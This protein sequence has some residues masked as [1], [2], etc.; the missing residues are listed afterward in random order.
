[1]PIRP[2]ALDDRSFNDLV[3]EL[4]ARIPAHTPEWTTR[5]GDPGRTSWSCS[6]GWATPSSTAPT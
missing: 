6:P 1:M 5:V 3:E 2:P 4:L